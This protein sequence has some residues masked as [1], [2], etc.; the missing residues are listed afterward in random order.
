MSLRFIASLV[1][2]AMMNDKPRHSK[3][4][5]YHLAPHG[6]LIERYIS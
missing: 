4:L 3:V 5:H 2:D 1:F 6:E